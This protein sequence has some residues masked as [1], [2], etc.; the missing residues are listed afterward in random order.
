MKGAFG[1][2]ADR[3]GADAFREMKGVG[4]ALGNGLSAGVLASIPQLERDTSRAIISAEEAAR[5]AAQSKSPSKLFAEIGKDLV[6]GLAVGVK[7]ESDNLRET[8][9]KTFSDWYDNALDGLRGK[10]KEARAIFRDFKAAI[11]GQLTDSLDIG[12]AFESLA[13]KQKA[14]D[15]ARKAVNDARAALGDAPEQSALDRVNELQA[16]Y[17]AA[18]ANAAANGGTLVGEFNAQAN[19]VV[20]FA[21][22]MR[23]LM[24]MGLNPALWQQVYS[25]GAEKGT[26]VADSLITGGVDAINESNAILDTVKAEADRIGLEAATKWKQSGI[27]SAKATVKGFVDR[28]GP[29]GA[30]RKRLSTLMDNLANSMNRKATITV[31]TVFKNVGQSIDGKKVEPKAKGGPVSANTTYLVGEQGPELLMLGNTPGHIIPNHDLPMIRNGGGSGASGSMGTGSIINLTVNAGMG[32]QGAEVGRQI[33]DALKAYERRN[34]SV[35]V[36]A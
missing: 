22:K 9:R 29:S 5:R 19:G 27:D 34:G 28:F 14:A 23:A 7:S 31:E 15:E 21:E 6:K 3:A 24:N 12:A 26:G 13:S 17:D 35:Y 33:V 10:V 36:S 2:L 8:L 20:A 25:L 11:S 4:I 18:V 16:A 32:T 30:G 1:T